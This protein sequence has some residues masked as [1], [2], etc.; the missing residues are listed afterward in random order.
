MSP[1]FYG[2]SWWIK[3]C[4]GAGTRAWREIDGTA[5]HCFVGAENLGIISADNGMKSCYIVSSGVYYSSY[6]T[7]IVTTCSIIQ[8]ADGSLV[9]PLLS[10]VRN[11]CRGRN[12]PTSN[13]CVSR[14]CVAHSSIAILTDPASPPGQFLILL[15]LAPPTFLVYRLP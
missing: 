1:F 8:I 15:C 2:P 9:V 6:F 7:G 5:S 14:T 10:Q 4:G 3:G 11:S 12:P 13:Y